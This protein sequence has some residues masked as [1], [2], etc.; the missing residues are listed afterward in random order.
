MKK[1]F[2]KEPRYNMYLKIKIRYYNKTNL[3]SKIVSPKYNTEC[4][5]LSVLIDSVFEIGENYHM[6]AYLEECKYVL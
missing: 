5:C 3:H 1:G 6:Q 4:I 2:D